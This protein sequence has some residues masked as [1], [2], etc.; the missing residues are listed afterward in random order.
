[1]DFRLLN[2][3]TLPQAMDLWDYC[4]EKK[5]TPFFQWY[6]SEY[7]LKQNKILGGFKGT[8]LATMLH[9]NPYSLM[10]R[11]QTYR[12]PYIVGVATDPVDR[13]QHVM[14][15]LMK[16][17][18]TMLRAMRIP[19]V[20]LMPIYAGIYQPYGFRYT[21]FRK[22]Y[23]LPLSAL[24]FGGYDDG[25]YQLER[26]PTLSAKSLI[27]PVYERAA[28]RYNGYVVRDDRVWDN[29]LITAEQDHMETVIVKDGSDILGYMLYNKEDEVVNVQ[30]LMSVS[31]PV[32]YRLM[33]YLRGLAG[34]YKTL[35]YLAACDDL[36]YLRLPDQSMAPKI[37]PFMM[38]RIIDAALFLE[39]LAV[40][41]ALLQDS[42]VLAIRDE[43]IPLNTMFVKVSFTD[44]GIKL[45]NTLEDPDVLLDIGAFT[46]L[47]FGAVS[48]E[49]LRHA[50]FILTKDEEAARKLTL[51]FPVQHN[52]INEYF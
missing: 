42:L 19:F 8:R 52:Y 9:L 32:M 18:F 13:G 23:E 14:G 29:L 50:G 3:E 48:V 44:K 34:T 35:R 16:T 10:L 21:H 31:A 20:I 24:S 1:M 37:A 4:F 2:K 38:G 27:A 47:A 6:F 22:Q 7:C 46:Q 12:V 41:Q 25:E 39:G 43:Q 11:G 51:L 17:A 33:S 36:M 49:T 26:I 5:D 40:P 15:D 28:A 30:E 45:L